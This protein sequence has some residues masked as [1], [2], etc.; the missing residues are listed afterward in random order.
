MYI[1]KFTADQPVFFQFFLKMLMFFY[2]VSSK[3]H[4]KNIVTSDIFTF[5]KQKKFMYF[6]KHILIVFHTFSNNCTKMKEW[7]GC[8]AVSVKLDQ[9]LASC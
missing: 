6:I 4:E 2:T 7:M 3:T 1:T 5:K 9:S 8:Q